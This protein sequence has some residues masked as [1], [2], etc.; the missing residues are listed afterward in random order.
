MTNKLVG[1]LVPSDVR[2]KQDIRQIGSVN[3]RSSR[4]PLI[5]SS[6][7]RLKEDIKRI[8]NTAHELPLYSFRYIGEE[9]V[10]EG[11]MAQDVLEVRPDAVVVGK[12][13]YYR[14]DYDKLGIE[15]RRI[16]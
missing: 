6:D 9:G 10:F 3:V 12:D 13:G 2:L 1:P 14:V 4:G 16:Q 5:P 15:L 8:G 7:V 11:G